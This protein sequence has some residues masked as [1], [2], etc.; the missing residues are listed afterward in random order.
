MVEWHT[1]SDQPSY[2]SQIGGNTGSRSSGS[3]RSHK[4]DACG[5]NY[6]GSSARPMGREAAKNKGKKKSKEAALEVV[7]NEWVE[8]KQFKEKELERLDKIALMQL[9]INQLMKERTHTKKMKMYLKLSSKE[10][11]DDRKKEMLGKLGQ[12]LFGN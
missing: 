10:H 11:L 12:E 1:L 3:K 9:E 6:V 5:S 2:G 7:D 4:S 8:F